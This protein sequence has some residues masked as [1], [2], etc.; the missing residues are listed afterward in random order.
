[1]NNLP[2]VDSSILDDISQCPTLNPLG[3]PP[4]TT[5][6]QHHI[7]KLANNKYPGESSIPAEAL[8]ALPPD[9]IEYVHTLLQDFWEGRRNYEEWQTALLRVLYKKG[10]QKEPTNYQGIVLQDAFACL[11]SAII[12][13]QLHQLI[14]K[15]GMEEPFAYQENTGTNDTTYCLHSTL[16]LRKEHQQDTYLLFIDLIKAFDTANHDLLF[17]ILEKYGTP[18][19]L[20]DII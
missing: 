6:I 10:H 13:G 5:E 17:A 8:K 19:A 18:R 7:T 15:C 4:S 3:M 2:P 11:L 14:K 12:G 20:I 16:Q 9:G 1:M